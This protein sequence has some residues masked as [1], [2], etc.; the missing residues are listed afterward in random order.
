MSK[1]NCHSLLVLSFFL[2]FFL[3]RKS[4]QKIL[5]NFEP[6][7]SFLWLEGS[8]FFGVHGYMG[9]DYTFQYTVGSACQCDSILNGECL[10][11]SDECSCFEGFTGE[12]CALRYQLTPSGQQNFRVN[13]EGWEYFSMK[14]TDRPNKLRFELHLDG[15]GEDTNE[16]DMYLAA[17]RIPTLRDY[18]YRTPPGGEDTVMRIIL[19]QVKRKNF[20][21]IFCVFLSFFLFFV[22][23]LS[24]LMDL[25]KKSFIFFL[26]SRKH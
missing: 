12:R 25:I 4:F 5:G 1:V 20:C 10:G 24:F 9:C 26:A 22:Y 7:N 6:T 3:F 23:P 11:G 19:S 15:E 14:V 13:V 8:Y 21:C 17:G 18:D 2:F 16:A